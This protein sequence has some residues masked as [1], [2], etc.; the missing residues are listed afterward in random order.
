[1][2]SV[3]AFKQEIKL[4]RPNIHG[5]LKSL[6]DGEDYLT[7]FFFSLVLVLVVLTLRCLLDTQVMFSASQSARKNCYRQSSAKSLLSVIVSSLL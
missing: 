3:L 5:I 6:E 7:L 2:T 4:I 1:M